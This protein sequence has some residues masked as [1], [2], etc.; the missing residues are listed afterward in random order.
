MSE[1]IKEIANQRYF[2]VDTSVLFYLQRVGLLR[3]FVETYKVVIPNS[4]VKEIVAGDCK[5]DRE[6][7]QSYIEVGKIEIVTL[8]MPESK[9]GED[10]VI[11]IAIEKKI[12]PIF[13]DK[14]AV[15]WAVRN[16]V[17]F[18]SSPMIPVMLYLRGKIDY[19]TSAKK[20]EE[21]LNLGYYGKDVK[22][23]MKMVINLFKGSEK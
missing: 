22:N 16:G 7:I 18:T 12:N 2:V 19:A 6:E 14:R 3:L 1:E 8:Q 17:K 4:V 13:D 15:I 21:I 20:V 5:G 23:F 9:K 10:D 11:K